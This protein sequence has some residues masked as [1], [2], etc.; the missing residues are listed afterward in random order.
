MFYLLS[1]MFV[2]FGFLMTF[3][4]KYGFSSVGYNFILAS[5]VLEWAILIEGWIEM[6]K[7]HES[8]FTLHVKSLLISDFSAAA[9]LISFGAVIGKVTLSQLLAMAFIEVVI[10]RF[11]EYIGLEFLKAYDIGE[12]IYVHVFGAYFGMAVAKVLHHKEIENEKESSSYTS[13]LFAM[14]GTV[15]LWLYWVQ[16][17]FKEFIITMRVNFSFYLSHL[18]IQRLQWLKV[19]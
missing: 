7:H 2:G 12:S 6:I 19:N 1:M 3:L 18:S 13:D 10:Q 9:V 16:E 8:H 5:F 4:R 15:F 11:N 14:I 17:Y